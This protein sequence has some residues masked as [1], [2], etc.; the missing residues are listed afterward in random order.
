MEWAIATSIF[1]AFE[2][3]RAFSFEAQFEREQPRRFW[4]EARVLCRYNSLERKEFP[5]IFK[6][7]LKALEQSFKMLWK[8]TGRETEIA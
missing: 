4:L 1:I 2:F 5:V 3:K 8:A 6:Q 7:I